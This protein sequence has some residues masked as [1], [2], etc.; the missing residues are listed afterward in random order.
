[1]PSQQQVRV[2]SEVQRKTTLVNSIRKRSLSESNQSEYLQKFCASLAPKHVLNKSKR[3]N[4][5]IQFGENKDKSSSTNNS[6]LPSTIETF[7][8][9]YLSSNQSY[10][11]EASKFNVL[12]QLSGKLTSNRDNFSS[13]SFSH[14]SSLELAQREVTNIR[15]IMHNNIMK[16]YDRE[17]KLDALEFKANELTKQSSD[18]KLTAKKVKKANKKFNF[19]IFFI[20]TSVLFVIAVTI[21]VPILTYKVKPIHLK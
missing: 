6:T 13:D 14:E 7:S 5:C 1:M 17:Y 15:D 9:S 20:I 11:N 8:N 19:K 16:I 21:I 4:S 18:L 10:N 12:S 3:T 2:I